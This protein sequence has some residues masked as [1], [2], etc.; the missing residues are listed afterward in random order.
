MVFILLLSLGFAR[1]LETLPIGIAAHKVDLQAEAGNLSPWTVSG[2]DIPR[3]LQLCSA[4]HHVN[5]AGP[6][7]AVCWLSF[8]FFGRLPASLPSVAAGGE[9]KDI[10]PLS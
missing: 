10:C 5:Q 6:P 4:A 3:R 2:S 8:S 7:F 9:E 1:H